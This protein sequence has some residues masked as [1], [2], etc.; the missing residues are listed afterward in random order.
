MFLDRPDEAVA[1]YHRLLA[2]GPDGTLI[3]QATFDALGAG[4]YS[5]PA[6]EQLM[7]Q[8]ASAGAKKE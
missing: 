8:L 3:V 2:A 4:G 6:M 5:H 1:I 7:V